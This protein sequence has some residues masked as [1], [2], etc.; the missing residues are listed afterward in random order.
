MST[1][2]ERIGIIYS[3]YVRRDEHISCMPSTATRSVRYTRIARRELSTSSFPVA[4]RVLDRAMPIPSLL[5]T[6]SILAQHADSGGDTTVAFN[7]SIRH[8]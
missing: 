6:L 1:F 3:P 5:T 4:N 7:A 2:L 8:A